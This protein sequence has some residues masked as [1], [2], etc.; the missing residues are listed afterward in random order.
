VGNGLAGKSVVFL[1]AV[2]SNTDASRRDISDCFVIMDQFF[3]KC[4]ENTV[5]NWQKYAGGIYF[6]EIKAQDL[7]N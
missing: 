4:K 1:Q 2:S 3:C 6:A 7:K 5:T